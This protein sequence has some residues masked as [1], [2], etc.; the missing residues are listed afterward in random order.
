MIREIRLAMGR[1]IQI[2]DF[3][4]SVRWDA[5]ITFSRDVEGGEAEPAFL[6]SSMRTMADVY[7][8]VESAMLSAAKLAAEE[9]VEANPSFGSVNEHEALNP[10]FSEPGGGTSAKGRRRPPPKRGS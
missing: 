7:A 4:D 9:E 5:A 10:K 2:I 3:K 6:Q 1:T 8:D